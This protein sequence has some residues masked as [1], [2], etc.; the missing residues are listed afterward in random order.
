MLSGPVLELAGRLTATLPGAL[1]KTL[2][3]TTGAE[4][5]EAAIK[6]A[7]SPVRAPRRHG[8]A[9]TAARGYGGLPVSRPLQNRDP[10]RLHRTDRMHSPLPRSPVDDD[11]SLVVHVVAPETVEDVLDFRDWRAA[12][13]ALSPSRLRAASLDGRWHTQWAVAR[14]GAHIVGLLP[15]HRS[16]TATAGDPIYDPRVVAP[17]L[18]GASP[19]D[20]R[21]WCYVGGF[22]DLMAGLTLSS[23][24]EPA[25][26]E[27]VGRRLVRA[28][29]DTCL[30]A[31]VKPVS[32]YLRSEDFEIFRR[33]LGPEAVFASLSTNAIIDVLG[34]S[35]DG[36]VAAL[37]KKRRYR[38]RRECA[39]LDALGM[40]AIRAAPSRILAE[41]APLI[42]NIKARHKVA[43]HPAL[44]ELRL[45]RWAAGDA[46]EVCALH[47]R[48]G[49]G[50]LVGVSFVARRDRRVELY[51]IGL[52]DDQDHRHL[53]YTELLVH[54]PLRY[55]IDHDCSMVDLGM[56]SQ[57]PK[58]L[59]GA[60]LEPVWGLGVR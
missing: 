34:T 27:I 28:A 20:A 2:L 12:G 22:M 17:A 3:L 44:I 24:D 55:A 35:V 16:K 6:M 14:R 9:V 42:A 41:A 45:R 5:N 59:R 60:R 52:A 56:D 18:W 46:D 49:R 23:T 15:M 13:L 57:Q 21:T 33:A 47:V 10:G 26:R 7:R 43:D 31:G 25:Q 48:D 1:G 36:H 4:A 19:D 30:D 50:R 11:R 37:D 38:M 8:V 40:R 32:L 29:Y 39:Q 51:E 54:A 53:V 58:T